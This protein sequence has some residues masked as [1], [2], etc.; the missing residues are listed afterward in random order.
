MN[1]YETWSLTLTYEHGL[2]VF[3]NGLLKKIF[4]PKSEE[5][6]GDCKVLHNERLHELNFTRNIT[7]AISSRLTRSVGHVERMV[8]RIGAYRI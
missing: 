5:L 3:H 2:K 7:R 1:V 6:T 4:R 8:E